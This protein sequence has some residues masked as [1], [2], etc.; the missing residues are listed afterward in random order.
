MEVVASIAGIATAAFQVMIYLKDVKDATESQVLILEE[1]NSLWRIYLRLE[2]YA[3][4]TSGTDKDDPTLEPLKELDGP[5][6]VFAQV[7]RQ[8]KHLEEQLAPLQTKG[9][10]GRI[11]SRMKWPFQEKEAMRIVGRLRALK[12]STTLVLQQSSHQGF[13]GVLEGIDCLKST[14]DNESFRKLLLWLSPT[15]FRSKQKDM[16]GQVNPSTCRILESGS[17]SSWRKADLRTL[18]IYGAHGAGK[19]VAAASIY[20]VLLEQHHTDNY[21]VIGSFCSHDDEQSQSPRCVIASLLKQVLQAR[22][23]SEVPKELREYY[24]RADEQSIDL[25]TLLDILR[26][27]I[28]SRDGAFII[29]DGLD[30]VGNDE[31]RV[32]MVKIIHGLGAIV[33]IIITSRHSNDIPKEIQATQSCAQCEREPSEIYWRCINCHSHVVCE[34][35]YQSEPG[36]CDTA[37]THQNEKKHQSKRERRWRRLRYQP[38]EMEIRNYVEGSLGSDTKLGR[39]INNESASLRQEAI[40]TTTANSKNM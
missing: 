11:V 6:G 39:L 9:I 19:S 18:W 3:K 20:E 15:N 8:L 2:H 17:F 21:F 34:R 7:A 25:N 23:Q 16:L 14:L 33:K 40:G 31:D 36:Q 10:F 22:G 12:N 13:R 32:S 1:V 24:S 29:L 27:E 38:Q 35:C 4:S 26:D 37:S 30:E 5:D 28:K